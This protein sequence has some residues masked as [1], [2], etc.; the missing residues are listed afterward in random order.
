MAG[1]TAKAGNQL[2]VILA[3][4][5]PRHAGAALDRQTLIQMIDRVTGQPLTVKM[6]RGTL[7]VGTIKR[8]GVASH[9]SGYDYLWGLVDV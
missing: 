5:L 1:S 8:A 4:T 2:R 6:S 7:T 3:S 9:K